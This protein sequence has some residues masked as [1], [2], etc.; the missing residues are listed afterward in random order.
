MRDESETVTV[1]VRLEGNREEIGRIVERFRDRAEIK[2]L[3]WRPNGGWPLPLAELVD[4][5]I[6]ARFAASG[7]KSR[8]LEGIRGGDMSTPHVHLGDEAYL[9]EV[10]TFQELVGEVAQ[11]LAT[12]LAGKNNYENTVDLMSR[13]AID[14]VPL[15][16]GPVR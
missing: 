12:E 7:V 4:V 15:P 9:L 3:P 14:T 8:Q 11:R 10:E 6:V 5:D 13:F 1:G 2:I 16:E